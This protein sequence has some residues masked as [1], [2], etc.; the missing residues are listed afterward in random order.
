ML[1][2]IYDK[3]CQSGRQRLYTFLMLWY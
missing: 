3:I 1:L 2:M